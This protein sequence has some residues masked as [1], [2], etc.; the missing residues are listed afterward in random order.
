M[1][2]PFIYIAT[3]P[4]TPGHADG[5]V[6]HATQVARTVEEQEPRMLGFYFFVDDARRNAI[7][8]QVHPDPDSMV[9]HMHAIAEHLAA[10]GEHLDL[11]RATT[12]ALGTPPRQVT[13][14]W[15][16]YEDGIRIFPEAIAAVTRTGRSEEVPG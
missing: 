2:A 4:I 9:T 7:V 5:A 11:A 16:D 1:D 3:Y 8:V 12:F 6:E 14:Y 13:D 10:A 15:A